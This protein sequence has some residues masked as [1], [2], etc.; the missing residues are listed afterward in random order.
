MSKPDTKPRPD[1]KRLES[2]YFDIDCAK[3]CLETKKSLVMSR[4]SAAYTASMDRRTAARCLRDAA[5]ILY[6]Q[7]E[8]IMQDGYRPEFSWLERKNDPRRDRSGKRTGEA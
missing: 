4:G 8:R 7:A 6:E 2:A 3:K 1:F 5:Y